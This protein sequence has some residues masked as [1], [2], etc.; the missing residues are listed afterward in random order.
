MNK[1]GIMSVSMVFANKLYGDNEKYPIRNQWYS[2]KNLTKPKL[3]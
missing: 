3:E 1:L 2:L